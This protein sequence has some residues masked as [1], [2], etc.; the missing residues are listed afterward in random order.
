MKKR[1]KFDDFGVSFFWCLASTQR[2]CRRPRILLFE[3]EALRVIPSGPPW[4][5]EAGSRPG[6]L[7]I[8]NGVPGKF[9]HV[10]RACLSYVRG[11]RAYFQ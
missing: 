10:D 3:A 5:L 4:D 6:F 2:V 7:H 8:Q 1:S 11:A 9:F